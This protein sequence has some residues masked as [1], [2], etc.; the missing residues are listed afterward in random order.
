MDKGDCFL[1]G[2]PGGQSKHLWVLISD[3]SRYSGCGVIVNLSKDQSR[4]G[5]ECFICCGEHPWLTE[6]K[7]WVC[8]NDALLM[9][10]AG[11]V[12]IQN[13]LK[14]GFIIPTNPMPPFCVERIVAAARI[15]RLFHK[16][17][18]QFLD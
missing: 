11:W 12:E 14:V 1:M 5:G 13:G 6:P 8:F 18:I 9:T 2:S 10:A 7:S 16:R 3:P 4:S 17:L 15:S